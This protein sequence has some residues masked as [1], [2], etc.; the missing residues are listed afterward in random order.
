MWHLRRLHYGT[1]NEDVKIKPIPSDQWSIKFLVGCVA[2]GVK[3]PH[4]SRG[5]KP[6]VQCF[7]LPIKQ[8]YFHGMAVISLYES[9]LL[10]L[11]WP[12]AIF[13]HCYVTVDGQL[14][15]MVTRLEWQQN[16]CTKIVPKNHLHP[17]VQT[18]LSILFSSCVSGW[19]QNKRWKKVKAHLF[20]VA[21][22]NCH[23]QLSWYMWDLRRLDP[24]PIQK[25]SDPS[26]IYSSKEHAFSTFAPTI[27]VQ[28]KNIG[29]SPIES[30]PF[31]KISRHFATSTF[32]WRII[33]WEPEILTSLPRTIEPWNLVASLA[34]S[35]RSR[36]LLST[37]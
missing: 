10:K 20:I 31:K 37:T 36:S 5:Y 15:W 7:L 8:P 4:C 32:Y 19:R 13:L 30:L 34:S 29:V 17:M 27:M 14:Q 26:Q 3:L 25:M 23:Q 33:C 16:E 21:G 9:A 11:F 1:R 6:V 18:S 24:M 12:V 22:L 35:I 2:Y 28:L